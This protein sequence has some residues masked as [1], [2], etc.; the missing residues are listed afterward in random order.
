MTASATEEGDDGIEPGG[1]V[2]LLRRSLMLTTS[3][4]SDRVGIASGD[5]KVSDDG[6]GGCRCSEFGVY[7][8]AGS[9]SAN[10][11]L[12]SG[13]DLGSARDD[14]FELLAGG[15]RLRGSVSWIAALPLS[16]LILACHMA[17]FAADCFPK[18]AI[19]AFPGSDLLLN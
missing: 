9:D 10:I 11:V 2:G 18:T 1:Q 12:T 13:G 16:S 14:V 4:I 7:S 15:V 19:S 8:A 6:H 3:D 5:V 17:T